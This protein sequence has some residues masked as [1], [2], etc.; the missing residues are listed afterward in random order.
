MGFLRAAIPEDKLLAAAEDHSVVAALRRSL[1][2]IRRFLAM[3]EQ[4]NVF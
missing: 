4:R 2:N 3:A 1:D